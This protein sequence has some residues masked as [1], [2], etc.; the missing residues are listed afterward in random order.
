MEPHQQLHLLADN[1]SST[2]AQDSGRTVP[3]GKYKSQPFEVLLADS[4][5]AMWLMNSMFAKL[6]QQYPALLAFLVQRYGLPD[7]TPEHN[8]LQNR[9]LDPTFAIRF[10]L[11]CGSP[12][13]QVIQGLPESLDLHATWR[14]VVRSKLMKERER[15]GRMMNYGRSDNLA[16]LRERLLVQAERLRFC[17]GTGSYSDP[18]W[19][20]PIAVHRLEFEVD[21]ADVSYQSVMQGALWSAEFPLPVDPDDSTF[22]TTTIGEEHIG[23]INERDGFRI[24]VKPVVGDDYPAIL[25]AMKA[26]KVT[27]LLVGDYTGAGATW[28]E[29]THIFALSNM[30]AVRLEAVELTTLPHCFRRIGVRMPSPDQAREIVQSEFASTQ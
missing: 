4:T 24:E 10:A 1:G 7:R 11:A 19:R 21:G 3:F 30:K 16:S 25:R 6:Q 29:L 15:A 18:D 20:G 23:G 12:M 8:R 14:R 28:E 22:G 17:A 26:V 5:Y 9:F 2:A 13:G 27:H